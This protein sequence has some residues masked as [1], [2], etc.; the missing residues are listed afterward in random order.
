V[1][2]PNQKQTRSKKFS[3]F[4]PES[5]SGRQSPTFSLNVR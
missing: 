4:A 1:I 2:S 3:T 5:M